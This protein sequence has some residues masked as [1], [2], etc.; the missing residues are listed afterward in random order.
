MASKKSGLSNAFIAHAARRLESLTVSTMTE[1]CNKYA[2]QFN[3]EIP[4]VDYP[5]TAR[6]KRIALMENLQAFPPIQQCQ[7]IGELCGHLDLSRS[8]V[9]E[10]RDQVK[11]ELGRLEAEGSP[12]FD[13]RESIFLPEN[14]RNRL[15]LALDRLANKD[16]PGAVTAA[17]GAVQAVTTPLIQ[18]H[19]LADPKG[20]GF[21]SAVNCVLKHFNVYDD[22]RDRLTNNGATPAEATKVVRS[23]R[24]AVDQAA[25]FLQSL[26]IG[27]SD[28]HD[29]IA[30][31]P[32]IAYEAV[33]WA[34]CIAGLLK[35]AQEEAE[36]L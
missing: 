16:W 4:H 33:K 23:L 11:R 28:V 26:R 32:I 20:I 15:Q 17:C 13:A 30:A 19:Q 1:V 22:L 3:V 12:P 31:D 21:Q 6:N 25:N 7:I 8:E 10:L 2:A 29:K 35:E 5:Y 24:K 9:G 36:R 18:A 27:Q 14:S 34:S